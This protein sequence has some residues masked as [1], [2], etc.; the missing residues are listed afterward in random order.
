MSPGVSMDRRIACSRGPSRSLGLS[1]CL[2][3]AGTGHGFEARPVSGRPLKI[4][5]QWPV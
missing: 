4:D 5:R 1:A 3:V 2:P